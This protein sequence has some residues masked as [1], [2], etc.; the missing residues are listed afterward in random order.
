MCGKEKKQKQRWSVSVSVDSVQKRKRV[1]ILYTMIYVS[2]FEFILQD[3][4]EKLGV[5]VYKQHLLCIK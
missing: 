1:L 3:K 2:T 5:L 4:T